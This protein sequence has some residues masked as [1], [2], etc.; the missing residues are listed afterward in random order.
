MSDELDIDIY[1]ED[2]YI[3]FNQR[4]LAEA[5]KAV[6]DEKILLQLE[7]PTKSL[8]ILPYNKES[9]DNKDT[10][11]ESCKFLYLVLPVRLRD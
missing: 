2:I 6:K 3:G 10:D 11:V 4:Y 1:G 5:V 8:V 7:S 9:G